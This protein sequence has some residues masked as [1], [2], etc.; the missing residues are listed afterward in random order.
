MDEVREVVEGNGYAAGHIDEMGERYGF[1]KVR[2]ALGVTAFGVNAIVM[3]A[4]T[5]AGFHW[6]DE[7]EETY[8]VHSGRAEFEFDG[9]ETVVL[10]PGGVLRVDAQTKRR[11][12]NA[13]DEDVVV[14]VVGGKDGYV[15]RDGQAPSDEPRVKSV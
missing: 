10:G 14:F 3:P 4:G 1:R 7:Q 9:G 11:M 2:R 12:G 15:G 13:G 8:F 5:S 6:H